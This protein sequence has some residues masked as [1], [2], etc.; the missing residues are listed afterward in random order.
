VTILDRFS[1]LRPR[2]HTAAALPSGGEQQMLAV[3]RGLLARPDILLLD[4]PSLGLAPAVVAELFGQFRRALRLLILS[5]AFDASDQISSPIAPTPI[6]ARTPIDHY[7]R[8]SP[9]SD[10]Y[11]SAPLYLPSA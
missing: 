2:L 10:V 11:P 5:F 7:C 9:L 8:A 1:R 6:S 3:A 4:N